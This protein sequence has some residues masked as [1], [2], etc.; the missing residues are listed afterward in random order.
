LRTCF[1][2]AAKF[3]DEEAVMSQRRLCPILSATILP[4]LWFL[5][6]GL[7]PGTASGESPQC[8]Q[9]RAVVADIETMLGSAESDPSQLLTRLATARSLC[10]SLGDAWRLS[11]CVAAV[12]DDE[13]KMRLY[14]DRA[15]FNGVTELSCPAPQEAQPSQP[16]PLP[17]YVRNKYA[18]IIGIGRFADPRIPQL[19]YAAKDAQDLAAVLIDPRYGRFDPAKVEVLVDEAATRENILNALQE[20]FLQARE[21]DLVFLY[22]S[23]HGSGQRREQGLGGVGYIVTY[24]TALDKIWLDALDYQ[25]FSEKVSLIRAGRKAIFLD[26]CFSGQALR[27]GEKALVVE[28]MGIAPRTAKLFLSGE[29]TYVITSSRADER[30]F[31]SEE[32]ENSYFTW[33]LMQALR[34]E[35]PPS[36]QQ[37]FRV[38]DQE[39]PRAVARDFQQSQHP[40]M[41]P[42]DGP[43]DLRIGVLSRPLAP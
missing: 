21:E 29:G 18:L 35:E 5:G 3:P 4:A 22:V 20:L 16:A 10:P 30:S 6:L 40:Q 39:V 12:L 37:V 7:F 36:I 31:E 42:E 15:L 38:L 23:T 25:G 17:S 1:P 32:L 24:D 41:V 34:L 2:S 27:R 11:S 13:R 28:G 43:G 26:T 9:A 33:Y 8:T 19:R 14:R